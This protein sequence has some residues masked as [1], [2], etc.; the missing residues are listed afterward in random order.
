MA[1]LPTGTV[2]FLFTD[3]E[4][5]TALAQAYPQR[6]PEI[7][8]RHHAILRDAIASSHGHTF[9]V[10][11]DACCAAFWTA[12]DALAATVASQHALHAE[13]WGTTP[14]C[15]RMGQHTGRAAWRDGDYEGCLS[16]VRTQRIMSAAYGG[17]VLMSVVT[18]ELLRPELPV[19]IT[20]RDL[21]QH[22]LKGLLSPEHLF[23]VV[24]PD[25]PSTFPPLQS[26]NTLPN[27]LPAALTSFVGREK[28]MA[29]VKRLFGRTRLLTLTGS[30][31]AGKTRLALELA[32]DLLDTLPD[33][34]WLAELAPLSDPT[35]VSRS[36]ATALGLRPQD[37]RPVAEVVLDHLRDKDP[38]LVLDNC[39]H[40]ID[41]CAQFATSV[42]RACPHAHI[43]ATSREAL[44]IEGETAYRVPSL[45][46]PNP[47]NLP[48]NDLAPLRC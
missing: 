17:Q 14:V 35:F 13:G 36:V 10:I 4:G 43:L 48:R 20:L 47:N 22:R 38:L 28:E 37:N 8:A 31:G 40:L 42:L 9:Q 34:A 45:A 1:E 44:G 11:G 16:L 3:I 19:E 39:E 46:T 7:R 2:T 12:S 33:G 30:G 21:G 5:S 25:L 32:A 26:L 6:W 15:V 24:L 27:N 29:K 23:Q 41:A 18:A